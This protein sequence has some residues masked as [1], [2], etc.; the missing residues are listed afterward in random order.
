M[1]DNEKK[2][3]PAYPQPVGQMKITAMSNGAVTVN[4]FPVD[5]EMARQWLFLAEK[6]IIDHFFKLARAGK[7]DENNRISKNKIIEQKKPGLVDVSGK[8]LQ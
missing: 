8:P 7:L 3:Q 1:N 2:Q 4:G 5:L 6:A